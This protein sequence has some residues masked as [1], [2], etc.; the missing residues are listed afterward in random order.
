MISGR[1]YARVLDTCGC[2]HNIEHMR[3]FLLDEVT[4]HSC[5]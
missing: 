3:S 2:A 1:D 5:E 4:A